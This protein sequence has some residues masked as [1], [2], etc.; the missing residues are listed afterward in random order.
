MGGIPTERW[1]LVYVP[2]CELLCTH[3]V[4]MVMGGGELCMALISMVGGT[5]GHLHYSY[6][7]AESQWVEGKCSTS[8]GFREGAKHLFGLNHLAEPGR[9]FF[10]SELC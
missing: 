1:E 4:L 3:H 6:T 7:H 10:G 9:I 8:I 5:G 2:A